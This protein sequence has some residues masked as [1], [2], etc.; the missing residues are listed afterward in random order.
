VPETGQSTAESVSA[1]GEE[2]VTEGAGVA[3]TAELV[4]SSITL[5]SLIRSCHGPRGQAVIPYTKIIAK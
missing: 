1:T 5:T 3:I 4:R 2:P